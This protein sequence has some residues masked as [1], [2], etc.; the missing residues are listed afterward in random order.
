[1]EHIQH[2]AGAGKGLVGCYT[3]HSPEK[4]F[5]ALTTCSSTGGHVVNID[6]REENAAVTGITIN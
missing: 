2:I 6:S 4:Y 1:M 3:H 5:D